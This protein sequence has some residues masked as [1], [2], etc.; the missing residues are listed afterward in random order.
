VDVPPHVRFE[1]NPGC[2]TATY[3]LTAILGAYVLPDLI[4]EPPFC[5]ILTEDYKIP[6]TSMTTTL[7]VFWGRSKCKTILT[8]GFTIAQDL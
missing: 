6:T 4:E 8:T 1:W 2:Y 3:M 5:V 7:Q